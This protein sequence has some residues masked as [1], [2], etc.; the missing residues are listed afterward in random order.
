MNVKGLTIAVTGGMGYVGSVT[1]K[2]LIAAGA[3][4]I[5]VDRRYVKQNL[6]DGVRDYYEEE[7]DSRRVWEYLYNDRIDGIVHCAATSLVGPSITDPGEYYSN[8]VI[9]TINMLTHISQM[10]EDDKPFVVFSS[11]AATYGCP[12]IMP[13]TE[14]TPLDPVNPYGNTKMMV[15]RILHDFDVA[16][17]IKS[18]CFRYFNAAGADDELGPEPG[19]THIIPRIFQAQAV[20]KAFRIFGSDYNTPDGTCVRDYIHV[21]DLAQAHLIG[22]ASLANGSESKTYNLGTGEGYSNRQIVDTFKEIAGYV[23]TSYEP[24]REGDPDKLVA[25]SSKFQTEMLWA[26]VN[27]SLANIIKTN[28]DFY[29]LYNRLQ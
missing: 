15:E 3:N 12:D 10:W 20:H 19:D 11:S 29:D 4:V 6:V 27:S 23:A 9:R 22:C 28:K 16:Y 21:T 2:A 14:S 26:P 17:G 8:N 1:A 13:I 24:R 7:Y 5:V 18:F 25:D